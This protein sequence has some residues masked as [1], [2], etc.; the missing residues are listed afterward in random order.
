MQRAVSTPIAPGSCSRLQ[1]SLLQSASP[2]N[3]LGSPPMTLQLPPCSLGVGPRNGF[4]AAVLA[5]PLQLLCCCCG[6]TYAAHV[7][8]QLSATEVGRPPASRPP[9]PRCPPPPV[10]A[11]SVGGIALTSTPRFSFLR[12]VSVASAD[13]PRVSNPGLSAC[14]SE[15]PHA[16]PPRVHCCCHLLPSAI[17]LSVLGSLP[18]APGCCSQ[19]PHSLLSSATPLS[20]LAADNR[21]R[22]P[23]PARK[24]VQ[25]PLIRQLSPRLAQVT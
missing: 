10:G 9:S 19:L 12:F 8:A 11:C 20:V 7:A 21:A 23:R 15:Q 5:A 3:V 4:T 17:P 25:H 14:T 22:L 24:Q 18:I 16:Y 1:H 13:V 6:S 2:L